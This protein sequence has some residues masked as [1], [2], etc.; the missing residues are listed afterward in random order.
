MGARIKDA[1]INL[2]PIKKIRQKVRFEHGTFPYNSISK[3]VHIGM[4]KNLKLGKYIFIGDN[5]RLCCE[6]GLE[7]GSYTR[8]GLGVLIVTSNHNYKSDK[9]IPFDEYDYKQKVVIGKNCWLG[10][11]VTVCP[12][13]RIEEGAIVATG[14]VVTKSVPRCA[15]VG[16]N[17]AKIIGFRD[18]D[19]YNKL[20]KE[21]KSATFDDVKDRKWIEVNAH[22][23]YL[24]FGD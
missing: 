20:E 18:I 12:G 9:F 16:G 11:R 14:S 13:V 15:I 2:I 7:I 21:G 10:A 23:D 6:G 5:G 19:I 17:P 8:I 22:K 4:A 3:S 1:L 24:K